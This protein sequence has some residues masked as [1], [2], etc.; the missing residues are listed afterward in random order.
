MTV[1]KVDLAKWAKNGAEY[2]PKVLKRINEVL[3]HAEVHRKIL[4][5][6]HSTDATRSPSPFP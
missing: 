4:V 3:P 5:D 2:L 6:D 1:N